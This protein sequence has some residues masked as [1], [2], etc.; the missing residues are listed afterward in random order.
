MISLRDRKRVAVSGWRGLLLLTLMLSA[1]VLMAGCSAESAAEPEQG[2]ADDHP[3]GEASVSD[4]EGKKEFFEL[5]GYDRLTMEETEAFLHK[6]DAVIID[7]RKEEQFRQGHL[8]GAINIYYDR[9]MDGRIDELPDLDQPILVY[10]D[11]GGL[12]G[13]VADELVAQGYTDV[14]DFDGMDYWD[15]EVVTE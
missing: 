3:A 7:V 2:G 11:Y 9:F 15:G 12:S 14:H 4:E 5:M 8:P 1:A 13:I 6:K 10:C